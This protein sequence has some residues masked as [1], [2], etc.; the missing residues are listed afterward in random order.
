MSPILNAFENAAGYITFKTPKIPVVSPLLGQVVSEGEVISGQYLARATREPV[1][2]V[3]ALDAALSDDIINDKTA[4][5]DIGPHP[6]CT[7]FASA[8]FGRAATQTFASLR[9]ADEAL[10]TLT[11]SLAALHCLG[12]S[13]AWNEYFDLREDPARLLHLDRYQWNYKNYWIQY[14]GSWTLDKAHAG[15]SGKNSNNQSAVSSFFTSSVQQIISEEYGE[16]IG[17]V[18]AISDLKHPDMR[19]AADGHKLNG[20]SV[21]TGVSHPQAWSSFICYFHRPYC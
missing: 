8:H 10:S 13:V 9:R 20:R 4:W 12:L 1:N 6:V 5:I 7:S 17:Q 16:N 14:E 18:K 2:F 15:E 21:V 19:G 11:G 3:A